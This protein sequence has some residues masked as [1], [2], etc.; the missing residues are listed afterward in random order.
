MFSIHS[1]D[2]GEYLLDNLI[3]Y[4]STNELFEA[5]DV[6]TY[7]YITA[8]WFVTTIKSLELCYW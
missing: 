7:S 3:S 8:M 5:I 6:T 4:I 1:V 2:I